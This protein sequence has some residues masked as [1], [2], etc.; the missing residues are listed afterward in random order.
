MGAVSGVGINSEGASEAKKSP[1]V[2]KLR[3]RRSKTCTS[4][5]SSDHPANGNT[6]S[7]GGGRRDEVPAGSSP[8]MVFLGA[9][10][11]AVIVVVLLIIVV[12]IIHMRS[13]NK[14]PSP[15]TKSAPPLSGPSASATS[16]TTFMQQQQHIYEP[17]PAMTMMHPAYNTNS[18]LNRP[19]MHSKIHCDSFC[20]K[21]L[22]MKNSHQ[23]LCFQ[24]CETTFM[25]LY[26]PRALIYTFSFSWTSGFRALTSGISFAKE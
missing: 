19:G 7:G 16:T 17:I 5:S 21:D 15:A 23:L 18:L 9:L 25:L 1:P 26:I 22:K 24:C 12:V 13:R 3:L 6:S 10:L 4:G 11:S 20:Q 14:F 8:H 2:T